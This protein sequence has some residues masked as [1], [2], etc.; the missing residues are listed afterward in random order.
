MGDGE[1]FLGFWMMDAYIEAVRAWL[2]GLDYL[3]YPLLTSSPFLPLRSWFSDAGFWQ[4]CGCGIYSLE[5]LE[6]LALDSVLFIF[7]HRGNVEMWIWET[8]IFL[9]E[10]IGEIK[11]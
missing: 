11:N 6:S 3:L 10:T 2:H 7:T 1:A 5:S 8:F 9:C 4:S